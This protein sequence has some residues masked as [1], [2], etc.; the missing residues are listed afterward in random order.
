MGI[1][2]LCFST[3]LM[4]HVVQIQASDPL[5]RL[6]TTNPAVQK[7]IVDLMNK[8]RRGVQPTARNMLKTEWSEEAAEN[9]RRWANTCSLKHS[10]PEQRR[11]KR[12]SC[13][14]NI[15][16]ASYNATWNE[17]TMA[18]YNECKDFK[19]GFGAKTPLAIIGHYTQ[20]VW[21][22]SWEIGCAVARCPGKEYEYF[23][24]CQQC[25]AG[26]IGSG[27]CPYRPGQ[28]CGDCPNNCEDGLCNNPCLTENVYSNCNKLTNYCTMMKNVAD[29]CGASCTCKDKIFYSESD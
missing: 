3:L 26:N 24:V 22:T 29:G 16:K 27:N 18:F 8:L 9:A 19:F 13:G 20:L 7:D 6:L 21:A 14:E 11:T 2:N 23:Y 28:T 15:F 4:A 25:P 5:A 17:A 1:L 10:P 12:Y